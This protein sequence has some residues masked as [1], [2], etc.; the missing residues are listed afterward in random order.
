MS[1]EKMADETSPRMI[2]D[3]PCPECR[4]TDCPTIRRRKIERGYVFRI[5]RCRNCQKRFRT[6]SRESRE[7]L[8][9]PQAKTYIP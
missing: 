7:K 2:S 1:V 9:S 4:S 3:V 5:R 6:V 8:S